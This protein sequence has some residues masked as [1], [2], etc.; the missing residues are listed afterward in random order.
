MKLYANYIAP[1]AETYAYCL[2]CNHFHFMVRIREEDDCQS[3]KDWQSSTPSRA[4][5]NLFSTYTKA[6]NKAYQRSGSLFEKPFKRKPVTDDRYFKRLVVYIHQNSKQHGLIDDFRDW[7]FSSYQAMIS[8]KPTQLSR[9]ATLSWFKGSDGLIQ[10]HKT[11]S[12][13]KEIANLI[14]DE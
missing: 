7:P 13:F 9:D 12:D 8:G 5:S 1:V 6:I 11:I 10:Y 4:F 2:L 3:L 14:D